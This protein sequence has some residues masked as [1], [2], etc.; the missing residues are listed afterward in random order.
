MSSGRQGDLMASAPNPGASGPSLIPHQ[1]HCVVFLSKTLYSHSASLH[2]DV[3][4]CKW[5]PAI[6]WGNMT[7]CGGMTCDG[8][9][10]CPGEVHVYVAILLSAYNVMLQKLG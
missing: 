3:C 10:S 8:L 4:N 7:N 5:V 1:G 9:A 6:C 2:P